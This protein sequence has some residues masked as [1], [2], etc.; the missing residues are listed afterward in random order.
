M[1][2]ELRYGSQRSWVWVA[3]PSNP[4]KRETLLLDKIHTLNKAHTHWNLLLSF[5]I[6]RNDSHCQGCEKVENLSEA[7][8][9][10]NCV[11][12][13]EIQQSDALLPKHS[14]RPSSQDLNQELV[15][16][17]PQLYSIFKINNVVW[18]QSHIHWFVIACGFFLAPMSKLN[19]WN[20]N[21]EFLKFKKYWWSD[22][23]WNSFAE[24]W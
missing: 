14:V 12:S 8:V 18:E 10:K 22:L 17:E 24:P 15:N 2:Q 1:T 13:R 6:P 11:L 3:P 19:R 16:Y 7:E 23:L 5:H 4:P 20:T 9:W 21:C